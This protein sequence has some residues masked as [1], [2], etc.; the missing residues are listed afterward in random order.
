MLLLTSM[1]IRPVRTV[2]LRVQS[3]LQVELGELQH[4]LNHILYIN[5]LWH[6]WGR[7]YVERSQTGICRL[8]HPLHDEIPPQTLLIHGVIILEMD[9]AINHYVKITTSTV[10]DIVL[11]IPT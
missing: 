5:S 6:V 1:A 10:S 4:P 3:V 2:I 11:I 7:H 9:Y 8:D